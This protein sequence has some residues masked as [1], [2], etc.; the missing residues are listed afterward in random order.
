MSNIQTV[1]QILRVDHA[2]EWGA[3]RIYRSQI[4]IASIFH[5]TCVDAL[6]RMLEHELQHF[7]TPGLDELTPFRK[8]SRS[9]TGTRGYAGSDEE[10][11]I[12]HRLFITVNS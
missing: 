8:Q 7:Q 10:P 6:Q 9:A 12:A 2:G 1:E 11:L 3:I 5:P 4:A